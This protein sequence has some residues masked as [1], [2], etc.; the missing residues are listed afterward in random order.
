MLLVC[1]AGVMSVSQG[2]SS[3]SLH[4]SFAQAF[5]SSYQRN[6]KGTGQ[7]NLRCFPQ[8]NA[9]GHANKAFC[10]GSVTCVLPN[11]EL[12]SSEF[13]VRCWGE[14]S[15]VRASVREVGSVISAAEMRLLERTREFPLL[16]WVPGDVEAMRA[17]SASGNPL[18]G[19]VSCGFRV[20]FNKHHM[21]WHYAWV[22]SKHTN[23]TLHEFR[24]LVFAQRPGEEVFR[25]LGQL[26]SA[27]F[28]VFTRRRPDAEE[29][30]ADGLYTGAADPLL[31]ATLALMRA[32]SQHMMSSEAAGDGKGTRIA[33]RA[34]SASVDGGSK[35]ASSS[36]SSNS[37]LSSSTGSV[38]PL[39]L[40]ASSYAPAAATAEAVSGV[41][42]NPF[43]NHPDAYARLDMRLVSR[44]M[45]DQLVHIP[46]AAPMGGGYLSLVNGGGGGGGGGGAPPLPRSASQQWPQAPQVQQLV[47]AVP[48]HAQL[49]K[50]AANAAA[51]TAAAPLLGVSVSSPAP[52]QS[53]QPLAQHEVQLLER[54]LP[55]S[56]KELEAT[57]LTMLSNRTLDRLVLLLVG[58]TTE[59][60]LRVKGSRPRLAPEELEADLATVV[61]QATGLP[62]HLGGDSTLA[63]RGTAQVGRTTSDVPGGTT[64]A[65]AAG[66]AAAA[67]SAEASVP[68]DIGN[69]ADA[70]VPAPVAAP[71]AAAPA[72]TATPA[73]SDDFLSEFLT[74][75]ELNGWDSEEATR[76]QG[77]LGQLRDRVTA[78]QVGQSPYET[79]AASYSSPEGLVELERQLASVEQDKKQGVL[80]TIAHDAETFSDPTLGLNSEVSL[81]AVMRD[82]GRKLVLSALSDLQIEPSAFSACME[83]AARE[84][85]LVPDSL[86]PPSLSFAA[87]VHY[88]V[89]GSLRGFWESNYGAARGRFLDVHE[90]RR[91]AA[92]LL[93]FNRSVALQVVVS[94]VR[95][96][97]FLEPL[98]AFVQ[99]G[100]SGPIQAEWDISGRWLA[101]NKGP[102]FTFTNRVYSAL[103]GRH[104]KK[105]VSARLRELN[106]ELNSSCSGDAAI[107]S[108]K[109][110]HFMR[111][112]VLIPLTNTALTIRAPE[113]LDY[114]LPQCGAHMGDRLTL[115]SL[116]RLEDGRPVINALSYGEVQVATKE[117]AQLQER[118]DED[119]AHR[120]HIFVTDPELAPVQDHDAVLRFLESQRTL[121]ANNAPPICVKARRVHFIDSARN[122][123]IVSDKAFIMLR[124]AFLTASNMAWPLNVE[125]VVKQT[126]D[127][128]PGALCIVDCKTLLHR[129]NAKTTTTRPS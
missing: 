13:V 70:A 23:D 94:R 82:W 32:T 36:S 48:L 75:L 124:P 43:F 33:K 127:S 106:S 27:P 54:F 77:L 87:G 66:A 56:S 93:V 100:G 37:T 26:C 20:V 25:F 108:T 4:G 117:M 62:A 116:G 59:R 111:Q 128:W 18:G 35:R 57:F 22:S 29:E 113:P 19:G 40:S 103:T 2:S 98:V 11:V 52:P 46:A 95:A 28:L 119:Q 89:K 69:D 63:R 67:A 78:R 49:D 74:L 45:L 24:A 72:A 97:V 107:M 8:H 1:V 60:G 99:G 38:A 30:G 39:P 84:R 76:M 47:E 105:D 101:D 81:Y 120:S 17:P 16:P 110:V 122:S 68:Q 73:P 51:P 64:A 86:H 61:R 12:P 118:S 6:N 91:W 104:M 65:A 96:N 114:L 102:P 121:M 83:V 125:W 5:S 53:G 55:G 42:S 31:P 85:F 14:F 3:S 9:S 58:F 41:G 44:E 109:L 92:D 50:N 71:A 90:Q 129:A 21:G 80:W 15:P 7:K 123:L 34:S 10:G 88:A 126:H 112:H 79:I 115:G